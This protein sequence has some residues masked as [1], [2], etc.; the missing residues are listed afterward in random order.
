MMRKQLLIALLCTLALL[1]A[2][3]KEEEPLNWTPS[4]ATP[5]PTATATADEDAP[6][7]SL[8]VDDLPTSLA[9]PSGLFSEE[10]PQV[11]LLGCKLSEDLYLYG[12]NDGYGGGVLLRQGENLAHFDQAFAS[13]QS[14]ALPELYLTDTDGDG[15]EELAVRYLMAA[16]GDRIAYDLHIYRWMDGT[17]SD[18][19]VTHEVC[20]EKAL[21][22]VTVDYDSSTGKFTLSYGATSAVYQVPGQYQSNPGQ[23]RLDTCFFREQD[24]VFTVVLGVRLD[25][26]DVLFANVLATIDCEEDDFTLRDIRVEPTTVV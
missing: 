8:T 24:G 9:D 3:G 4:P 1:P 13:P 17:C 25:T 22:E 5:Q 20:A 10:S 11:Y 6:W 2:C 19:A 26:T 23:L 14:P 16:Q 15:Q 21:A 18:L 7:S 12:L